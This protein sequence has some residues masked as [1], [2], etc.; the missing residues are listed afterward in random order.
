M[1][2]EVNRE[3]IEQDE[4]DGIKEKADYTGW[5]RA[6]TLTFFVNV[7]IYFYEI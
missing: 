3:E 6:Q 5:S 4:V 2:D 7:G 1:Q